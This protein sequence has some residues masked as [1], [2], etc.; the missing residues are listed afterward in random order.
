MIA[1]T[2]CVNY[3][4]TL[5]QTVPY[6]KHHF[7]NWVIVT[8]Y[9]DIDTINIC[10]EH[11][12]SFICTNSF[13]ANGA[14]FNKYLAL[15]EGLST[16]KS[17]ELLCILDADIFFPKELHYEFK[18]GKL[19]TPLRVMSDAFIPEPWSSPKPDR[20]WNGYCQIFHPHDKV[21][22]ASPWHETN[23]KHAGGGDTMFQNKWHPEDKRRP[24][25]HVLHIGEPRVNW[26]GVGNKHRLERYMELRA[27]NRD[28]REEKL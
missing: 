28:Y 9:D 5:C 13:Y 12:L 6:N 16:V 3:A 8:T 4:Q 18:I 10:R 21:L 22:G 26:C 2:V 20:D 17:N 25:F 19:Y 27:K 24:S 14:D 23:W 15:E 1:I 7:S 11:G